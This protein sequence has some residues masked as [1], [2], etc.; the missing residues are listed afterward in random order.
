MGSKYEYKHSARSRD[1]EKVGKL[2]IG[3]YEF[4]DFFATTSNRVADVVLE[5]VASNVKF[6]VY[7]DGYDKSVNVF[8]NNVQQDKD[9]YVYNMNRTLVASK[10]NEKPSK[11]SF[12][13]Y[14]FIPGVYVIRTKVGQ[15]LSI[16]KFIVR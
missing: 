8:F 14:L 2:D 15:K 5:E 12:A 16:K 1:R 13:K 11:I 10:K 6:Y 4:T 3:A 9:V 7:A